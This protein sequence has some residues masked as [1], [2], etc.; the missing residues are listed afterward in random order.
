MLLQIQNM[1]YQIKTGFDCAFICRFL[2]LAGDIS[3]L[4]IFHSNLQ[5][6]RL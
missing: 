4:Y 5:T 1:G 3:D 2:S 6:D